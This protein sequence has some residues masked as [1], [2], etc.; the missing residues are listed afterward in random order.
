MKKKENAKV[1]TSENTNK[2]KKEIDL[3]T[4]AVLL[5]V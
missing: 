4:L 2:S 1:E 5:T 3:K